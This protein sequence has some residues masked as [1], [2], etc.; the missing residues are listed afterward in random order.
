MRIV[1]LTMCFL[2]VGA[3]AEAQ[4]R[5]LAHADLP[6]GVEARLT[7][8]LEHP[9][10]RKLSG[11]VVIEEPETRDI[12]IFDGP[13]TVR[14][15]IDGDLIIIDGDVRF[16]NGAAVTGDVTVIDGEA[17]GLENA[18]IDGTITTYGEGFNP[19]ERRDEVLSV[20]TRSRRVY[21]DYD[22]RDWGHS[23]FTVRTGWNYNRV[24]G[25]PLQFGP[26]VETSGRNPTRLEALAIWRTEVSSPFD[27]DEWGYVVRAEQFLG[28]HRDFRVGASLRSIIDPIESWDMTK[29]EASLSTALLHSDY[30]DYYQRE[31]WSV[32]A[33][34]TPRGTGV[35]ATLEYADDDHTSQPARDPWTL[36]SN[37]DDWRLQPLVAEGRFRSI[38]GS[39]DIDRRNSDD[40]PTQGFYLR[41]SVTHGIGGALT[42]P[43]NTPAR[44]DTDFTRGLIDARV[45]RQVGRDATLS[46]RGVAGGALTDHALPPQFQ[47]ALGGAGSLP[48]YSVFSGDCG[49]RRMPLTTSNNAT[50][51]ASYGCDRMAMLSAEYRGGF[52]FHIGGW[53]HW[54]EDGRNESRWD[55]DASPDWVVFFDGGRGWALDDSKERGA[56]DTGMLYDAGLGFLLGDFGVYGAVPLSGSDRAMR[57]FIRL[58]PR[59]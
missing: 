21:R 19:F 47:H 6:R 28:G 5:S 49:A 29:S 32:Y 16:E 14:A 35:S 39:F 56:S 26:V 23:S 57:F 52:D 20:N 38:G 10:T 13:A 34:V 17:F 45:Y 24:E 43:L 18:V 31:G 33:R 48:G 59:F 8:I 15:K 54:D 42:L 3:A 50:Y 46:F 30:R 25:L 53:D 40:F 55:L 27:T 7:A 41:G 9:D 51:F 58:G 37:G 22:H 2:A 44:V 11:D 4:E 1:V 36:F 12:V